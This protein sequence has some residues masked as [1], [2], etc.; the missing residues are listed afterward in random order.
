MRRVL[1][2]VAGFLA[3]NHPLS[4]AKQLPPESL[5]RYTEAVVEGAV[6]VGEGGNVYKVVYVEIHGDDERT[7]RKRYAWMVRWDITYGWSTNIARLED[8]AGW[9]RDIPA[10]RNLIRGR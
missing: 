1:W 2:A 5:V 3:L 10:N 8:A 4:A 6:I 9:V 7:P